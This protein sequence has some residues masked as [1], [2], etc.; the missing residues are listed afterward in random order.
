MK[1]HTSAF[2]CM[3]RHC[4]ALTYV[5]IIGL[6]LDRLLGNMFLQAFQ[7][8]SIVPVG[9]HLWAASLDTAHCLCKL[10][11]GVVHKFMLYIQLLCHSRVGRCSVS[12]QD[13]VLEVSFGKKKLGQV[14]SVN[15]AFAFWRWLHAPNHDQGQA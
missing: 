8:Q 2:R 10:A 5:M 14:T 1:S 7:Q 6:W 9:Q 13:G 11:F 12:K 4:Q 3:H 15:F